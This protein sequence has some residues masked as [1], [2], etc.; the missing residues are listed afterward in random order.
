[1]KFNEAQYEFMRVD[2]E[3]LSVIYF[4]LKDS[5]VVYV[6]RSTNGLGVAFN[7]PKKDYDTVVYRWCNPEELEREQDRYILKYNPVYNTIVNS[8]YTEIYI[9]NRIKEYTGKQRITVHDVRKLIRASGVKLKY[10]KGKEFLLQ[11]DFNTFWQ[12]FIEEVKSG[13]KI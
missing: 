8:R 10:Y 2:K 6:G 4:L 5:H 3:Y 1:M 12:W 13:Q 7:H 9:K 11:D